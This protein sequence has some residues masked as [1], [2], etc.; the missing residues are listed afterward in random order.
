MYFENHSWSLKDPF[1]ID[2][3]TKDL[4]SASHMQVLFLALATKTAL[5]NISDFMELLSKQGET[6]KRISKY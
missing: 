2:S 4:L 3:F 1:I 5:I 6:Y